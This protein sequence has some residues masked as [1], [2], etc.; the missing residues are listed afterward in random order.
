MAYGC[1]CVCVCVYACVKSEEQVVFGRLV[2][3]YLKSMCYESPCVCA[4]QLCP[5]SEGTTRVWT[6]N[7]DLLKLTCCVWSCVC[8]HLRLCLKSEERVV[9]GK[10]EEIT[11]FDRSMGGYWNWCLSVCVCEWVCASLCVC[12]DTDMAYDNTRHYRSPSV[13]L[14]CVSGFV[15][16]QFDGSH[17]ENYP[18]PS[19]P[20]P[21]CCYVSFS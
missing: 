17:P 16:F 12:E 5:K 13:L 2:G 1:L 9:F 8:I 14:F 20:T 3:I 7:G 21:L 6:A 15:H 19:L 18:L 11:V 10:N 4:L